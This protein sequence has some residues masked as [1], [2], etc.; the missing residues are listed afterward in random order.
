M[1]DRLRSWIIYYLFFKKSID[2]FL[3]ICYT[4][5]RNRE[6]FPK[7]ASYVSQLKGMNG[8]F[9]FIEAEENEVD[10]IYM[11]FQENNYTEEITIYENKGKNFDRILNESKR[12]IGF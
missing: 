10:E 9:S 2:N 6:E 12:R 1:R 3:S 11:K 4:N 8:R 5:N 7:M